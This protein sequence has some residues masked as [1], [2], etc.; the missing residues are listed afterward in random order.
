MKQM[1][2]KTLSIS[3]LFIFIFASISCHKDKFKPIKF[4]ND[5]TI[6]DTKGHPTDDS[7]FYF[8]LSSFSFSSNQQNKTQYDSF[9]D[10]CYSRDLRNLNEPLLYNVYLKKEIYRLTVLW[11]FFP[12]IV[13]R[14]EFSKDSVILIEK[15][16]IEYKSTY[17]REDCVKEVID[18]IK[19]EESR[20][21]LSIEVWN[22]FKDLVSKNQFQSMPSFIQYNSGLDGSEW[23]LE[24]HNE[25][26]Y[27]FVNR[28]T[29]YNGTCPQFRN[30][31]AFLID[32]SK[33]KNKFRF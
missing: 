7:T 17:I 13:L 29:P 24:Q 1:K 19:L 15:K 28:W 25:N 30:L 33:F 11:A 12:D 23:I 4:S 3:I 8:P 9:R 21:V 16:R 5:L 22:S 20:K 2:L 6:S 27:Y 32:H 14:L 31:C 18:S 10:K 26:G